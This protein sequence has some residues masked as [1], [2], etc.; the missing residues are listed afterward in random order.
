LNAREDF[1]RTAASLP[2]ALVPEVE[3]VV[4]DGGSSDGTAQLA[5]ADQRVGQSI[6]EADRGVYDAYNKALA[7][8]TGHYV[9]YL[10]AGDTATADAIPAALRAI[11]SAV[12]G[13]PLPVH[14]FAIRM[15]D[16]DDHVWQPAPERMR[17]CMSVPT[18]GILAP[19]EA[20]LA[21]GGFDTS[22]RVAADFD[23]WLRLDLL[24]HHP[25][26]SQPDVLV[27][28]QGGGLSARQRHL[29]IAEEVAIQLRRMPERAETWLLRAVR[30]GI[31]NIDPQTAPSRRWAVALRLARRFL[32]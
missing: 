8:A 29:A 32:Y 22:Y 17:E 27:E 9:W 28:Y 6:S 23:A 1:E 16:R 3:W 15:V 13:A 14:C 19:R 10:N 11:G 4:V 2:A 26:L 25:I 5:R 24:G 7:M 20:L 31:A 21:I 18:P 30:Y 12:S